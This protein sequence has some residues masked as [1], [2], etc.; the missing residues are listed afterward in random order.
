MPGSDAVLSAEDVTVHF[1]GLSAL[2]GCP[3]TYR[4]GRS[5]A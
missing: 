3:C 5:S 1:G 2:S 4:P